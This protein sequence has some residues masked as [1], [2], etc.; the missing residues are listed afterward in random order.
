[1]DG[2]DVG[3]EIVSVYV[4]PELVPHV[5]CRSGQ[6]DESIGHGGSS[7]CVIG[8]EGNVHNVKNLADRLQLRAQSAVGA[9][10]WAWRNERVHVCTK[11][12]ADQGVVVC[13][14]SYAWHSMSHHAFCAILC[15]LHSE[16]QRLGVA[17]GKE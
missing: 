3:T 1:L 17:G 2:I 7:C 6:A 11:M 13:A 15:K 8:V 12:L 9:F 5:N 10:G 14:I 16:L 4:Y